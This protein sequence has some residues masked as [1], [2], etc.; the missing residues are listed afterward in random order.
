MSDSLQ[1][2]QI[3][4]AAAQE[5]FRLIPDGVVIID[6]EQTIVYFNPA[7]EQIFKTRAE[8]VQG[9]PLN[10]LIPQ[11][12]VETH[13][14]KVQS[15]L[16]SE[17]TVRW[18]RDR[19]ILTA[20]HSDGEPFFFEA[21]I[22]KLRFSEGTYLAAVVRDVTKYMETEKARKRATR[23]FMLLSECLQAVIHADEETPLL[24]EICRI[25]V[26]TGHYPFAWIGY[27]EED[28]ARTVR[29]L[30]W[31]GRENGYLEK[32]RISWADDEYGQGPT[33]RAIRTGTVQF[34]KNIPE[35]PHFSPW[36]SLALQQGF[37]A[38]AAFP[39]RLG[40]KVAGALNI[41]SSEDVFDEEEV[42][43]LTKLADN[44]SFGIEALRNRQQR[45]DNA[46]RL[47]QSLDALN[48]RFKELDLFYVL[49]RL[50]SREGL[51]LPETIQ[52]ILEAIAPAWQFPEQASA[53]IRVEGLGDFRTSSYS[54]GPYS[55]RE[56]IILHRREIGEV[57]VFYPEMLEDSGDEDPFL[58]EERELIRSLAVRIAEI[59][60][61]YS[62][63]DERYKLSEALEQTAD[64][65]LISDR[66]GT[67]EYINPAFETLSG[68]SREEALSRKTN[69]L[70][71]GEHPPEFYSAMWQTI[72]AG[73]IFRDTVINRSKNGSLYYEAKTISPLYDEHG[74]LTHFLSTGKDITGQ[75]Q[76]ESRLRYLASHDVLTG[77]INQSEFVSHL[78]QGISSLPDTESR[79]AV[80][81]LGLDQFHAVNDTLGRSKGDQY[82]QGLAARLDGLTEHS[83]ARI[84]GDLFSVQIRDASTI[85]ISRFVESLLSEIAKPV[86]IEDEE[87]AIT[88]TAGVS[89]YPDDS[90]DGQDLVQKA[91]T[92]M[93]LG[94][95][96]GINW[97]RFYT[98]EMQA[99]S[100]E[101]LRITKNL[102]GALEKGEF[103]VYYQPQIDLAT[104]RPVGAEALL[105]WLP[106]NRAPIPPLEFIPLLEEMG[107]IKE[108]G[109]FV[110]HSAC[111]ACLRLHEAGLEM[112][113]IAVNVSALQLQAHDFADRVTEILSSVGL[114]PQYLELE[115]TESILITHYEKVQDR[116]A[117]LKE[118]GVGVA[119]DDFGTG[120]SSL[121]YL[122][123]YPF[124]KLKIDK[125]F[126]WK[127]DSS[128]KDWEVIKA[129]VSLGHSL[130]IKVNAEGAENDRHIQGLRTAGCDS[131]QGFYH[132]PPV[133]EENFREFLRSLH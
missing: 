50:Q 79:I 1:S 62:N 105:R 116:L 38:S 98:P 51:S 69:I 32:I 11:E 101:R 89:F 96:E 133:P 125:S 15:F 75:L 63:R 48:E 93:S 67:I 12:E 92:A 53:R 60:N 80:V 90:L 13:P 123:R 83:V 41:Y 122:T 129:I 49:S 108:V 111:A 94:K 88:A 74:D 45:E 52:E 8:I 19:Q 66:E 30:A 46:A 126:V 82:L 59:V 56:P 28:E 43:L 20:R 121:Q 95:S 29:P 42:D 57:E 68:Y 22:A 87:M 85:R 18:L 97:F 127:M 25:T 37:R 110:L 102:L 130:G 24:Q 91:E 72:L 36:R 99:R 17:E 132:S 65:V 34:A 39:L 112:P 5:L 70:K 118:L 35:D 77:L 3:D 58:P 81:V 6:E 86:N 131:V 115:I 64:A 84:G 113:R 73:N 117:E 107:M 128:R 55:L 54:T 120:Y 76:S 114:G 10:D 23:G 61:Y 44:L 9:R 104:G 4:S 26:E 21:T 33:G 78:D 109:E 71:S 119:L 100:Q 103:S 47:K 106:P 27:A 124:S 2:S 40:G 7:A 14:Q 31:S 16:K